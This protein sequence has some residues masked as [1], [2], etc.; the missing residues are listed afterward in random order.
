MNS[1]WSESQEKKIVL[2]ESPAC[3]AVFEVFLKYLYTGNRTQKRTL[4]F[5][6]GIK[7]MPISIRLSL[8]AEPDPAPDPAPSF[9][10]SK[11]R[12]FFPLCTLVPVYIVLSFSSAFIAGKIFNFNFFYFNAGPD[13]N[14]AFHSYK[15]PDLA[16]QNNAVSDTDLQL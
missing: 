14:P 15:D 3:S 12:I 1:K 5:R 16:S 4:L 9:T 10:P 6:I 11:I 13:P 8:D 2:R 7:T